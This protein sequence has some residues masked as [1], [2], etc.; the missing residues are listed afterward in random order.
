LPVAAALAFGPDGLAD[1]D[2]P[3]NAKYAISG[4]ASQLWSTQWYS[5]PEFGMLKHG[6]GLLLELGGD[7]TVSS[8]AIDLSKYPGASLQ[9]R[10]GNATAP[11]DLVVVATA[12]NVGGALRLKLP[13]EVTAR[14]LLIWFTEL[15]PDGAGHY[16]ETVSQV[17]VI[18]HR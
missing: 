10:A 16:Q 9:I 7:V 4:G 15:P 8:V 18:G 1:G 11:Q 14:Y 2:D 17:Q 3:G 13:N 5:T 6:T 12:R